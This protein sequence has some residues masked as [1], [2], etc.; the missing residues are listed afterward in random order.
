MTIFKNAQLLINEQFVDCDFSVS[1]GKFAQVSKQIQATDFIDLKGKKII[2]GL[3]DIHTHGSYGVDFNNITVDDVLKVC[4]FLN[5]Q[6]V[7]SVLPT[8]LTD[9]KET[10]IKCIETIVDTR[11]NHG[12]DTILGIHLEGPFLTKEY[13][14]AM[15]EH[16]LRLPDIDLFNEYIQASKGLIKL[17]TVSPELE[18][19][20]EFAK[21]ISKKCVISVGHSGATQEQVL[22]FL[23]SGATNV[24]HLGNA[25]KQP[26]QHNLNVNGTALYSDAYCEII[27][28]GFHVNPTVIDYY[29]KIKDHDKMIAITDCIMAGG[30][31]DGDYMLGVNEVTVTHG[32]AKLKGKDTRAGSTLCAI[33]AVKNISKFINVPFEKAV[34]FMTVN[35]AKSLGMFDEVGSLDSGKY[36]NFLVLDNDFNIKQTYCHGNKVY[37]V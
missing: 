5:S 37:S 33:N 15:P 18:G 25:M 29:F 6:G 35:P 10:T 17:T 26:T 1:N 34:K 32:D 2:P 12:C 27:C 20:C 14:G 3:I 19:A 4:G 13:K 22:K 23:E 31:P 7:T 11:D 36:A 28:D 30:L 9:T 24:T 21:E 16:L 8:V